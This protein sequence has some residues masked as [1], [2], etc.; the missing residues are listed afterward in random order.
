MDSID[1]IYIHT[2]ALTHTHVHT[3]GSN[4]TY[5]ESERESGKAGTWEVLVRDSEEWG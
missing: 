4:G 1:Y 5:H 3:Q 2:D